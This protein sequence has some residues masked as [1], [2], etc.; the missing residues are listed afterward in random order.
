MILHV[1]FFFI[2]CKA[3][4]WSFH[5]LKLQNNLLQ[6]LQKFYFDTVK[7]RIFNTSIHIAPQ[8]SMYHIQVLTKPAHRTKMLGTFSQWL[9]SISFI[10]SL[11]PPQ[12]A[13]CVVPCCHSPCF[14]S[15]VQC[16]LN[17]MPQGNTVKKLKAKRTLKE[18]HP[19]RKSRI[20]KE[21]NVCGHLSQWRNV[22]SGIDGGIHYNLCCS[23]YF[24]SALER[25]MS[26]KRNNGIQNRKR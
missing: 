22:I 23:M 25:N 24:K 9:R 2:V 19:D 17:S 3:T 16:C 1:W 18:N 26:N 11:F 21:K 15:P 8:Y 13:P 20:A 14:D 5:S 12:N 10:S 4:K 6:V 7:W